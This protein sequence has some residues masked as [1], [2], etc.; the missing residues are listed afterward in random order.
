MSRGFEWS[1]G[2]DHAGIPVDDGRLTRF[3]VNSLLLLLHKLE[4]SPELAF[5]LIVEGIEL[6]EAASVHDPQE[7]A[8]DFLTRHWSTG[9]RDGGAARELPVMV[10]HPPA[11]AA[12][13]AC[14]VGFALSVAGGVLRLGLMP[15][16]EPREQWLYREVMKRWRMLVR[17]GIPDPDAP[18]ASTLLLEEGEMELLREGLRR[19]PA[20][21]IHGVLDLEALSYTAARRP[22]VLAVIDGERS[23]RYRELDELTNRMAKVLLSRGISVGCVVG[24]LIERSLEFVAAVCAIRKT[25]ATLMM[26]DPLHPDDRVAFQIADA[27]PALM[28]ADERNISRLRRSDRRLLSCSDW[29]ALAAGEEDSPPPVEHP[30]SG[31]GY[32]FYTSGTTGVPKGVR[33]LSR[34]YE[35][36]E[37]GDP[38]LL[39][40][41]EKSFLQSSPSFTLALRETF[42]A[43]ESA[44][45][46]F[47]VPTGQEKDIGWMI[48]R[49]VQHGISALHAAPSILARFARHPDW[50]CCVSLGR[51]YTVGETLAPE[52]H[53]EILG[54]L[55]NARLFLFYGCTEAP[56]QTFREIRRGEE[57]LGRFNIGRPLNEGKVLIL[58]G[59]R[60][61]LPPGFPGEL[62]AAA[63]LSAGYLNR[64]ELNI[65]RFIANPFHEGG[66][67][68]RT[69][70]FARWEPDGSIE[71]LGRR[72]RQVQIRGIRVELEEL[73]TV[74]AEHPGVERA[75][76]PG[77]Y[78]K[79]SGR[80][81][82]CYTAAGPCVPTARELRRFLAARFPLAVI[83]Q[84]F[85]AL[86]A[87]PLL[88]SGK[89]D[90][91]ALARALESRFANRRKPSSRLQRQLARLYSKEIG[92]REVDIESSFFELGGDSLGVVTLL[93]AIRKATGLRLGLGDFLE[94]S[95]IA[96]LERRIL[97]REFSRD[98]RFYFRQDRGGARVTAFAISFSSDQADR[99]P[100]D[101]NV[102][103][104]KGIWAEDSYDLTRELGVYVEA[105][106]QEIIDRSIDGPLVIIGHS[107]GGL[108]AHEVA[109][110]LAAMGREPLGVC[111]IEPVTPNERLHRRPGSN[112]S[113]W[114]GIM[115]RR[116]RFPYRLTPALLLGALGRPIPWEFRKAASVECCRLLADCEK[117]SHYPGKLTLFHGDGFPD[118]DLRRW[119][120]AAGRGLEVIRIDGADHNGLVSGSHL[121]RWMRHFSEGI[122]RSLAVL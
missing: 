12:A 109:C 120:S 52:L 81:G 105:Y 87:L 27:K 41:G 95:S 22:S 82:C 18:I 114:L 90:Q 119:E 108:I 70:D 115:R 48:G 37:H 102:N 107:F 33:M 110:R 74:L 43:L 11:S 21:L 98:R 85:L 103:L 72:D 91:A 118:A 100:R 7:R 20:P 88:E 29:E 14:R 17:R 2:I 84:S 45:T 78:L 42:W 76:I 16:R 73:E 58:D 99:F 57:V 66:R 50:R 61:P 60:L 55:P 35:R 6:G 121:D 40:V 111:L 97:A 104:G 25:G 1:P 64:P 122:R 94:E 89:V 75:V 34:R 83:P 15:P 67:L 49:I 13:P 36:L 92:A 116:R 47:I 26:L 38:K 51:I 59:N 32:L 63:N 30:E 80:L 19:E 3:A 93:G 4:R 46:I 71:F 10:L 106:L 86:E 79:N 69:G 96:E 112:F 53:D 9:I 23:I 62:H 24:T 28:V 65:E 44:A 56:S 39:P 68:Y 113:A 8:A 117:L 54:K 5:R 31:V 77:G 101:W